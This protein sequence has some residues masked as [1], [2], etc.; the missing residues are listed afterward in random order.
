VISGMPLPAR[1]A[2]S[3][4]A[5]SPVVEMPWTFNLNSSTF[6]AQRSASSSVTNPCWYRWKMD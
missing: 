5:M 4:R 3:S 1:R 2:I 6:D